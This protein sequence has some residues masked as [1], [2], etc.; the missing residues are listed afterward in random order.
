MNVQKKMRVDKWL[1][2]ARFFK[3]R[4]TATKVVNDGHVR[5]N[6][7]K[8]LK[9]ST[10]LSVEDVLTFSQN[11]QIRVIKVLFLGTRRGPTIEAQELYADLSSAPTQDNRFVKYEGKGRPS[12]KSRRSIEKLK[13][14]VALE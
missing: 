14:K 4:S 11:T 9:P 8:I 6:S 3:T 7:Q 2:Y 10:L 1:W 13:F 12:K 5:L